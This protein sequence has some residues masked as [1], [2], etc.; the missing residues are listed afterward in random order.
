MNRRIT[1][2]V[3]AREGEWVTTIVDGGSVEQER[4]EKR[5]NILFLFWLVWGER[6]CLDIFAL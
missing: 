4:W 5:E 6:E 2:R 3:E 1:G